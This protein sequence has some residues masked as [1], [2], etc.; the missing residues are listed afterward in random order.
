LRAWYASAFGVTPN[1]YGQLVFGGVA[2]LIEARDDLAATNPEPGR[3]ILNLHVE[4]ARA[5]AAHLTSLGVTWL[6]EVEKRDF[7]MLFGTLVG[8]DGNY[9]QI[10]ELTEEYVATLT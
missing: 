5:T 9:V 4:D 1:R 7:G 10:I 6:V 3:T 8:P 2:L